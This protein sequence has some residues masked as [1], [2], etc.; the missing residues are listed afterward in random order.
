LDFR[1][2]L[3][4]RASPGTVNQ[5][6]GILKI[7]YKEGIYREELERNPMAG[8]GLIHYQKQERG[9]LTIDELQLLFPA[10]ALGPW[11]D[12]VDHACFLFAASTGMRRGEILALR[13]G[14]LHLQDG[15]VLIDRAWKDADE[16]GPP[17]WNHVRSSVFAVLRDRV[18]KSLEELHD[19]SLHTA[20]TD[21]LFCYDDGE[22]LGFT[23]WKKRFETA[24]ERFGVDRKA[25]QLSPHS[26]RHTLA[27]LLRGA[28]KD[29]AL[30]RASLG[31]RS[32]RRRRT[33]PTYPCRTSQG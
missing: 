31:W 15:Y 10:E 28:G 11:K 14:Q 22:P 24:M 32:S 27:S 25:R 4:E 16:E 13:W 26:F 33:T 2:R 30:I 23:W 3:L 5:V 8:I 1:S 12:L 21:F 29:P 6:V 18:E 20:P 9:I 7:A 19:A 17:K